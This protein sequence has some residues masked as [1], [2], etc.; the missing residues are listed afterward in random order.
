[1]SLVSS[2]AQVATAQ[3]QLAPNS[4]QEYVFCGA[5]KT[6]SVAFHNPDNQPFDNEV[7]TRIFQTSSAT[8]ALLSE[9]PWKRL[10]VPANET[11]LASAALDF[12]AVKA[13]TKFVVQWLASTNFI[14]KTEVLV[15]PTNLL[16][17]L[18]PLLD[19][20]TL[21]VLDPNDELKPLL[22]Q[23]GVAYADLGQAT[24]E[25]FS[26]RLA[27]LG[28]FRSRA[29]LP[30]DVVKRSKAMAKN[31][32]AIV[33]LQ[34]PP[35][36]RDPLRPSYYSV[37]VGT[38]AIVVVQSGIVASLVENPLSQQM[39]LQLCRQVLHP[40]PTALPESNNQP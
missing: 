14:G 28:P 17:E 23:N 15:Y 7:H 10:Q 26:G 6:I 2:G 31:G 13:E 22:R 9:N 24:L 3:L 1:M 21:G 34:P 30:E 18:K 8:V 27:I 19:G 36:P 38:N 40:E 32:V 5:T 4:Q 12:P 25:D 33:W 16:A 39:L 20:E 11:V 35:G 37:S 29:Q